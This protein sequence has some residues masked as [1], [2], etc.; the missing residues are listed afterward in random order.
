MV[1]HPVDEL[2][3]MRELNALTHWLAI[4]VGFLIIVVDTTVVNIYFLVSRR[5]WTSDLMFWL[6]GAYL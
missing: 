1:M 4:C 2:G 3:V 6:M 5:S